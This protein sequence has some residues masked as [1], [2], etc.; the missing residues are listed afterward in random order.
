MFLN[1]GVQASCSDGYFNEGGDGTQ[2]NPYLVSTAL[3]FSHIYTHR[4]TYTYYKQNKDLVLTRSLNTLRGTYDGDNYLIEERDTYDDHIIMYLSGGI[5][6]L[7][8]DSNKTLVY[9]AT[10]GSSLYNI[11]AT[12]TQNARQTANQPYWGG[13]VK[14]LQ[15]SMEQCSYVGDFVIYREEGYVENGFVAAGLV[16]IAKTG[17]TI[18]N[19]YSNFTATLKSSETAPMIAGISGGAATG[20][21]F[22]NCY[23]TYKIVSPDTSY[24][25]R[26]LLGWPEPEVV[27]DN[28]YYS[29]DSKY[30]D[31]RVNQISEGTLMSDSM[32]QKLNKGTSV[33]KKGNPYPTFRYPVSCEISTKYKFIGDNTDLIVSL[34]FKGSLEDFNK[35]EV[36]KNNTLIKSTSKANSVTIDNSLLENN[37]LD[38]YVRLMDDNF[39]ANI[40]NH[41]IVDK[42]DILNKALA[43]AN[44]KT[45]LQNFIVIDDAERY[46][47]NNS[48]NQKLVAD[49]KTKATGTFLIYN[50]VSDVLVPLFKP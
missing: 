43:A 8:V 47:E 3:D 7:R 39:V 27:F 25:E 29:G 1:E 35:I 11:S 9:T 15:G 41:I 40:S 44:T 4:D 26:G 30:E 12:G 34:T 33:W 20:V 37:S 31:N 42:R 32:P 28:C 23:S 2:A 6:N 38:I 5:K 45:G 13:I 17:S 10:Q 14:I 48:G 19:C 22:K 16:G 18:T 24:L 46:F 36:L 50:V 21:I 49:I